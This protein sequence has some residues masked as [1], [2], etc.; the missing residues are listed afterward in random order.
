MALV[1]CFLGRVRAE[2]TA[3][4]RLLGAVGSCPCPA[5]CPTRSSPDARVQSLPCERRLAVAAACMHV[6]YVVRV[7]ALGKKSGAHASSQFPCWRQLGRNCGDGLPGMADA[8]VFL[9]SYVCTTPYSSRVFRPTWHNL[10]SQFDGMYDLSTYKHV[11]PPHANDPPHRQNRVQMT[12]P[13]LI[14]LGTFRFE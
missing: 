2:A 3:G 5:S 6:V 14:Y 7:P 9:L 8:P 1:H 13:P 10:H 4:A 12:P 11:H